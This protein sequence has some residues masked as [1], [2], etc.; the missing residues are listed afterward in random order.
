MA[1][2]DAMVIAE[3][4]ADAKDTQ[5]VPS[6]L[7]LYEELRKDRTRII[8]DGARANVDIW[9]LPDGPEQEVR[10]N[11]LI[12]AT[13]DPGEEVAEVESQRHPNSWNDPTFQP[14]LFGFDAVAD[15]N[16]PEVI[17]ADP[18]ADSV[19]VQHRLGHRD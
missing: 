2:E 13:N 11:K 19:Q 10:D 5:D 3:C 9:H 12:S 15:A 4:L 1:V 18:V 14:W 6:L 17:F 8:T 16:A 7:H